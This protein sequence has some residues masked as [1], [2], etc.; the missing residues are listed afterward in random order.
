[1]PALIAYF[2]PTGTTRKAA[3]RI[4]MEINGECYE[5]K[6]EKPY[7]AHDLDWT[8]RK[9]RS[10]AEMRDKNAR[11]EIAG[12]LPDLSSFS[13]LYIGFPI[14]WGVAP[15]IINSFIERTRPLGKK[16]TVFATSGGSPLLPAVRDLQE[17]YPE[18]DIES[19][20][21]I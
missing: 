2:S 20:K 16:V 13:E 1:M 19:G 11:P 14:W 3:E 12:P 6:A 15:R 7:T 21:L 18:L 10:S 17:K 9:S 4:A 8:D 5:I